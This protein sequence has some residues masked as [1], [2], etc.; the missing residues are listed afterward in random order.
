MSMSGVHLRFTP[1][2]LTRA[3]RE[4]DWAEEYAE[5]LLAAESDSEHLPS[6]ARSHHTYTAWHGLDFLLRRHGFP[7]DVVHG[8]EEIP[9]TAEWGYGPPR[10]LPPE[11]VR[12]AADAFAGLS[13]G[14]LVAGVTAADLVAAEVYPV[15][16]WTDEYSLGLVT[17]CVRPLAAYVRNTALRGHALLMWIA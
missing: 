13:P 8:E 15:S 12:A 6:T 5:E 7:V 11:R 2:E 10:F 1:A 17:A 9:G 4:P 3:L 16:Q 14:A